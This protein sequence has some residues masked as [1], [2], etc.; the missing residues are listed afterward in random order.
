MYR[1]DPDE[2]LCQGTY[3]DAACTQLDREFC[4]LDQ[5]CTQESSS[6]GVSYDYEVFK[7]HCI[8]S[9]SPTGDF[10]Y[11]FVYTSTYRSVENC[12]NNDP[13]IQEDLRMGGYN[14]ENICLA[15]SIPLVD[16]GYGPGAL[17]PSCAALD[18]SHT[19]EFFLDSK[20]T[21]QEGVL[22]PTYV[23]GLDMCV[24]GL[25][26]ATSERIYKFQCGEAVVHCK[27]PTE[28][29]FLTVGGSGGCG[30]IIPCVIFH[31]LVL[32]FM[33]ALNYL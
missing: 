25:T 26:E 17:I 29:E 30:R 20:C 8:E 21:T 2:G 13:P 15:T 31:S 16:G 11:P 28:N 1:R 7:A 3:L 19:V 24:P 18:Q 32:A 9:T 22:A 14:N 12:T 10:T 6:G 33:G 23:R 27:M 5:G 4:G